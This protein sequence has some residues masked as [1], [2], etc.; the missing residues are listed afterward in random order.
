MSAR[1]G[2]E[3]LWELLARVADTRA[4][5]L[6]CEQ[7][8]NALSR[9]LDDASTPEALKDGVRHHMTMCPEC[10]SDVPVILAALARPLPP[11]YEPPP[12]GDE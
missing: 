4:E 8:L 12:G 1:R 3:G 6:D 2:T 5:E 9:W 10:R 11:D 7:A